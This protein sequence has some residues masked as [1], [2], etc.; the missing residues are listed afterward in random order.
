MSFSTISIPK[1]RIKVLIGKNGAIRRNIENRGKVKL[2]VHSD[3]SEIDI[4][5]K[6]AL[7]L[8]TVENVIKAIARGFAPKKA[9]LL[10]RENY[11]FEIIDITAF[12][13]K[14]KSRLQT[15]RSRIIGT[16]GVTKHL[17]QKY[18]NCFLSIQ[19]K[20]VSIIGEA[21]NIMLAKQAVEMILDGAKQATAYHFL[22]KSSHN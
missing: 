7:S 1:A 5:A 13:A 15:L 20:T 6:D 8:M 3:T 14:S 11:F 16:N 4:N 22:E 2:Y 12:K 18:T 9:F 19:G 21:E 17:L 10:F